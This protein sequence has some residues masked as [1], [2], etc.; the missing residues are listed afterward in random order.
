[1]VACLVVVVQST[2]LLAKVE[3]K[4]WME[5]VSEVGRSSDETQRCL[6]NQPAPN[7]AI[8]HEIIC[9]SKTTLW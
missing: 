9:E 4:P 2:H 8:H 3:G 7:L 1:M 5:A 6:G